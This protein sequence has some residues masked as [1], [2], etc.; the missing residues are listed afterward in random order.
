MDPV[1]T[2]FFTTQVSEQDFYTACCTGIIVQGTVATIIHLIRSARKKTAAQNTGLLAKIMQSI[3][4]HR[5]ATLAL[6]MAAT[7]SGTALC[8]M[9]HFSALEAAYIIGA[10]TICMYQII[11]LMGRVG[12]APLG[13]FATFVLIPG[14]FLFR[15][16]PF[17]ATLVAAF[18]ELA[19]GIAASAA[20][21]LR[22]S[23]LFSTSDHQITTRRTMLYQVCGLLVSAGTVAALLWFFISTNGLGMPPFIAQ[24]ARTR[25]LLLKAVHVDLYGM[26]VGALIGG[27]LHYCG[28]NTTLML[29]GILMPIEST[30][31]LA[32]GGL[33][34][35]L[36]TQVELSPFWSGMFTTNALYLVASLLLIRRK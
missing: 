31:L 14:I 27:I 19:C 16:S 17:Q 20:S 3:Q 13:R 21:G 18:V 11:V 6:A 28:V 29:T 25:A 23:L 2:L 9:G 8:V 4:Q 24:R 36:T 7:L 35:T 30:L 12:L 34:S 22:A 10:S 26:G 33:I 15:Y 5:T 1:Y 32:L